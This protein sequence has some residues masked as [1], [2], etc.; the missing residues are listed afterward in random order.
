MLYPETKIYYDGSHYIGIPH[1]T[2]PYPRKRKPEEELVEV[3]EYED[4]EKELPKNN[5]NP[6]PKSKR[7]QP[8]MATRSELFEQFYQESLEKPKNTRKAY[9][10][11][12]MRKY[13]KSDIEAF[14]YVDKKFDDKIRSII[15][16]KT[17][18]IRKAYNNEFNYFV[19][20]TYSDELQTE[21]SFRKKLRMCLSTFQ[22]RKDWRYMGVWERGKKTER[23]HF[24][25]LV[26]IPDDNMVGELI[27]KTDYSFKDHR[28]RK[29]TQN[30]YF[31]KRFGRTDMEKLSGDPIE[32]NRTLGYLLKYIE[33]TNE[34]IVYSRGLPIYTISDIDDKDVICKYGLEDKKLLLFNDFT[35][36]DE[37]EIIGTMSKAT[38]A[39]LRTCN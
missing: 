4:I 34:K 16:R 3:E 19:T 25:A 9:I 6:K 7:D 20:F 27:E 2:N 1:S 30:T 14:A 36:M 28:K 24:H 29:I 11:T 10:L 18:F 35:A 5:N 13:F 26:W 37:G 15:A 33:K 12:K 39:K 17:R 32:Y 22:K 21:E 31:N 23:L 38:K 8:V